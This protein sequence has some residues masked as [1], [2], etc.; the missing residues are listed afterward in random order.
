MADIEGIKTEY[1]WKNK[2]VCNPRF[3][4]VQPLDLLHKQLDETFTMPEHRED[5]KNNHT[6]FRKKIQIDAG[7]KRAVFN[8]SADDYY[9]LYI[10]GNYVTQGPANSYA[11]CYYYNRVDVTEYLHPGENIIAVHVYYQ[12]LINRA[13]NSGDYRQG[14]IAD[15]YVDGVQCL[16][17]TWKYAEA[18]EYGSSRTIGY[19]T[20]YDEII[21][22]RVKKCG[23]KEADYDDSDWDVAAVCEQDDHVLI[24]Q[25]CENVQMEYRIPISIKK[26][27]DGYLLDFGEELTGTFYMR[28]SGHIGDE[29][30]IRFGEELLSEQEVRYDMRCNCLYEDRLILAE[31]ENELEQFEYKCFRYVQLLISNRTEKT[32]TP[33]EGKTERVE[34][35]EGRKASRSTG[36]IRMWDFRVD[37][38]HY[39]FD[40]GRCG[41]WSEHRLI[42]QIWDICKNAVRNC[43]QE[44]F[45]DCPS[46]EK[47]QYL[48]D[49]TVT[50]H[51]FY[52]LTG[53]TKLFRKALMDFAH[54]TIICEGMMAVAPGSFMQEIADFSLLY[55]YQLLLYYQ[56]TQDK[57]FLREMLPVAEG[58][59]HYFEK[60]RNENGMLENVKTK[61]NLVDW[62][63]NLRDNYDF[64]LFQPVVGDGCHNVINALYI[65]MKECIEEIRDILGTAKASD[66]AGLKRAFIESF[67]DAESGLFRDSTVSA[68]S[69]LHANVFAAFYGIEPEGNRIADFIM[70]KG[71]C[72]GV[73]VSYFVLY[74]LIR[75]G[76]PEAAYALIINQTE[77]SWYHMIKEGAAAAYEAWGKEQKWNTSLCHAWAAAPIPVLMKLQVLGMG[78]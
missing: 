1:V 12:G 69:S 14:M 51:A 70:E 49:L 71:L 53:D 61:W 34:N 72:C 15:L 18:P 24:L 73:F 78:V 19:E 45:L 22:N 3:Q 33:G 20:Q 76:R 54:S 48:G 27:E 44:A 52:C 37:Y 57:D 74:A 8:I 46:R 62:P 56:F 26:L 29:V 6:L 10:N 40:D 39:P 11:F 60:F 30:V 4:G 66:A 77:H 32:E 28:T 43:S 68:H 35:P 63:E 9:K 17:N 38:R 36:T 13:Y 42:R 58:I 21:D 50:A 75:L 65:G 64:G 7:V 59:E 25:P 55:P 67:Y 5:L 23:W 16:D 31:G 2:W 41:F 47:G